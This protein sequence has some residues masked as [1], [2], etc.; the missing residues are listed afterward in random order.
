M[1]P[2]KLP[3]LAA[4]L[5]AALAMAFA[6][7]ATAAPKGPPAPKAANGKPVKTVGMV[8]GTPTAFAFAQG[9]TFVGV[10]GDEA[11]L[12]GGGVFTVAGGKAT[13]VPGTPSGIA[14]LIQHNGTFY[15][16]VIG[17]K[18]G[19]IISLS[20]WN[21]KKFGKIKTIFNAASTVGSVSG[22][23]WRNG[24]IY[25]GGTLV[26]DVAKNGK[27]KPSP[28]PYP[29][30]VFSIKP[31]GSDFQVVASGLRQPW[32]LTFVKG[33]PNPMVSILSQE[34]APIP[35]DAIV[36][37]EPGKN[38]GFP[39]CFA[40]VGTECAGSDFAQP[41]ITLPQHASPMGIQGVGSTLY[42][43]LFGGIGKSGPEVVKFAAKAN[44][45]PTPVLTGYA[46]PVVALGIAGKKLY[47]GDIA[48][49]IYRASL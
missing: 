15:A 11:T 17:K 24:R 20:G 49:F 35:P 9:K 25:G 37:A 33:N 38:Y 5:C 21:G 34:A 8:P 36:N 22:L 41:F 13:K 12:K 2:R 48:G 1:T 18:G 3:A 44:A 30:S 6:S 19:K 26:N 16:S 29:Y 42:V 27:V 7:V 4:L 32:Q 14:G 23:A 47:T 31:D 28:F 10:F 43:A 39:G 46:A 45:K 40:G